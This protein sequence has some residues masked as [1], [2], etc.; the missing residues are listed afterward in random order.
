MILKYQIL[1]WNSLSLFQVY[2]GETVLAFYTAENPT[3]Q[4]ING[5]STYNVV[6]YE[7]AGYFNKIQCFCFDEQR[8]NPHEKVSF[9][10]KN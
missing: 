2:P 9:S 3:D 5:I 10:D 4:P 8:L 7:A 6:P 1:V